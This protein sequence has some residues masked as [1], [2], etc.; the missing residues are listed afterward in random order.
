VIALAAAVTLGGTVLTLSWPTYSADWP[1]R[2]NIEYW[3]DADAGQAHFLALCDATQLPPSLAAV[4]HFDATPHPRYAGSTA[5]A[6]YATAPTL[7]LNAPE[8]SMVST[9]P[10]RWTLRLR[11]AR[12]AAVAWA[13]FPGGAN[14]RDIQFA[15]TAGPVRTRLS[16]LK[17]GA[18]QL[19]VVSLPAAGVDFSIDTP[20]AQPLTVQIFDESYELA[21]RSTLPQARPPN[22]ASS[23]DGDVTVVHRTVTLDPGAGR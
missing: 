6:F 7:P 13:V 23:Q 10:E 14:I 12:G 18:T 19:D 15:T 17:S 16:R 4:G 2:I 8:L 22:A 20:P 9:T 11:S 3:L 21:G 1:Q 5:A